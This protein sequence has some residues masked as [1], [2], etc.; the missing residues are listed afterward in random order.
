MVILV[1]EIGDKTFLI[2]AVMAMSHA[3]LLVFSAAIGALL[4]MTIMS[5]AMGQIL[6]QLISKNYTEILAAVLFL[7]FGLKLGFDSFKLTGNECLEELEEVTAELVVEDQRKLEENE[8]GATTSTSYRSP[9]WK[10]C[11]ISP[12]WIQ[13]FVMTFLAEW[14]D[15][16]QIASRTAALTVAVAL[17]GSQDFL[18]V[19]IGGLLGHAICSGVAVVGGRMVRLPRLTHSWPRGYL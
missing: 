5:A 4:V 2:A 13:V 9:Y 3:R 14:G 6:P 8:A 12:V 1:S 18:Y 11:G 10:L 17:A 19:T 16:S 7:V 15:R